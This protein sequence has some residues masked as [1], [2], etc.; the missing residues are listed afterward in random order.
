MDMVHR[1]SLVAGFV[2][3]LLLTSTATA[4]LIDGGEIHNDSRVM[5]WYDLG[6]GGVLTVDA[7]GTIVEHQWVA[8][9]LQKAK[10]L[11]ANVSVNTIRFDAAAGL[12]AVGHDDGATVLSVASNEVVRDIPTVDPVEHIDWDAGGDLWLVHNGGVRQA[13][14]YDQFGASGARTTVMNGGVASFLVL[15]DGRI[16][17]GGFD[18]TVL[19]HADDGTQDDLITGLGGA[20]KV[21]V[22]DGLI[23]WIGL[24]D[25]TVHRYSTTTWQ[26][27]FVSSSTTPVTSISL[28]GGSGAYVGHQNGHVRHVDSSLSIIGSFQATGSVLAVTVN[29]DGSLYLVSTTSSSTRVR[30]LDVD[31]DGDGV[32]DAQDAFPNNADQSSD[33]DG[34]GYGDNAD[35]TDGDAFPNDPSQWSDRDGDGYGDEAD[36]TMPDAFPDDPNQW[37][38]ADGDG[39]GDNDDDPEGDVFPE[40]PTQWADEDRDGYGDNPAGYR[41]DDCPTSNGFSTNDRRGCTDRDLDGWSDPDE[42]WTVANGADAFPNERTQWTDSDGDGYGDAQDGVRPD[43]CPT[44]PGASI[45][46]LV[47]VIAEVTTYTSEAMF[48]CPDEDGDGW[49]DASEVGDGMADNP[50]EHLDQDGDGVGQRTDYN[51]TNALVATIEDHCRLAFDDVR[52][53]CLGIRSVEYQDYLSTLNESERG[54]M[55]YTYWNATVANGAGARGFD[56]R[57]VKQ[58][59][60]LA[61]LVFVGMTAAILTVSAT[62]KKRAVSASAVQKTFVGF[63]EGDS[64]A[65]EA[66]TGH[67][68]LSARGGVEEDALWQDDPMESEASKPVGDPESPSTPP[69]D[70]ATEAFSAIEAEEERAPAEPSPLPEEEA[71]PSSAPPVPESGL[72]EGWTE[73]QWVHYGHQWL[74]KQAED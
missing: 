49:A 22:E 15:D 37:L 32:A 14:E 12:V 16:L 40:D 36:G 6:D 27:G 25:G 26:G 69:E 2:L 11:D 54:R 48:G 60:M 55:T 20:V 8:G 43:A 44:V 41:P 42:G 9:V 65:D 51:D 64:I 13:V 58:V 62:S 67:A 4:S 53:I 31:S 35:A 63:G 23:L 52:D 70:E 74:A 19:I 33:G 39:V 38:D 1:R 46:A 30:L 66:L 59:A 45:Q 17:T 29:E 7:S 34:D 57:L 72:P 68:G 3:L 10:Q 47:P 61:G 28:D 21:L 18:G 24:A 5:A 71:T 56:V 73:E 50:T